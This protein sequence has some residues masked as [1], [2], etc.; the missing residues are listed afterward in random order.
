LRPAG[1]DKK[2]KRFEFSSKAVLESNAVVQSLSRSFLL[3][4]VMYRSP[5]FFFDFFCQVICANQYDGHVQPGVALAVSLDGRL[6]ATGASDGYD[7]GV[8]FRIVCAV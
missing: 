2:L 4:H 8:W 6:I 3:I 5:R 7:F 1:I